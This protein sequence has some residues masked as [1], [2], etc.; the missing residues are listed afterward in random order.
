[1]RRV[2]LIPMAGAGQR[3][4][5][6]GYTVPKPLIEVGGVP[7]AVR[8]AQSLPDADHWIFICRQEHI[9]QHHLDDVLRDHF[10]GAEVL[11]ID[12]LTEGQ[13]STCMLATPS[14]RDD[15]MLTI[16]AC[17]NAMVWDREGFDT[18][19]TEA[20]AMIWTF[21]DNLAVEQDPTM[22]GWVAVDPEGLVTRVSCKVPISDEPR[23]D[24]AVIG[25]FT[26]RRASTFVHCVESMIAAERRLNGEFYMD[27][28]LDE[29]VRLGY[30]VSPW[31]VRE[32]VCWGTPKD[33]ESNRDW[34]G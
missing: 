24:H 8:S 2:N 17:D 11:T 6:V 5:D 4:A 32:Y 7:M 16:G 25:A 1:M 15:D 12:R 19:S 28:A 29:C 14:L 30:R 10:A 18:A 31:E 33:Y 27:V 34:Q 3:F 20:D 21:R 22:Y 9:A 23:K 26:F 13:A